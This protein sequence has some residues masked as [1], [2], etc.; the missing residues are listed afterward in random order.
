MLIYYHIEIKKDLSLEYCDEPEAD[1]DCTLT[2]DGRPVRHIRLDCRVAL[3]D[4]SRPRD[5]VN[6]KTK[7][8]DKRFIEEQAPWFI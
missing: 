1:S 7:R 3:V 2:I 6:V 5:L 4:D 8:L